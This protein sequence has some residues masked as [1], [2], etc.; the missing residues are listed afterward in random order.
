[1][2]ARNNGV[3]VKQVRIAFV[4]VPRFLRDVLVAV[5]ATAE[6]IEVAAEY[7]SLASI[8]EPGRP[9][10]HVAVIVAGQFGESS[11]LDL[12]RQHAALRV[13]AIEEQG[14]AGL[15][16]ELR[17]ERTSL[18]EIS[19]QLLLDLFRARQPTAFDCS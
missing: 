7:E 11:I 6:D 15:L 3:Q 4:A 19:A 8:D 1:M 9:D 14:R 18:G 16:Y 17:P 5:L 10:I 13:L 2:N 12:L